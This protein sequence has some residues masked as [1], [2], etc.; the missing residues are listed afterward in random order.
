MAPQRKRE[1]RENQFYDVGV[2]GRK[3]GITL[4]DRGV[5]DEHGLEPIS[6]IFSS[7]ERSPPKRGGTVTASESMDIQESSI[8]DLTTSYQILRNSRT[9]LPPPRSRSPKKTALGSSPRRQSSIAPR[10]SSIGP[11][12]PARAASHP[13]VARRLDFEQDESSLQETPALSGSGQRRGK[14]SSVYDIPEDE[15]PMPQNS[16][17]LEESFVQEEITTNEDSLVINGVVEETSIA[18]VGDDTTN[19]AEA[20]ED[21]VNLEESEMTPEPVREPARR[22]RKRKSDVLEPTHQ[23]ESSALKPRKRGP[24]SAPAVETQKKGRNTVVVPAA[25]SRR[26]KR[27]SNTVEQE[28]STLDASSELSTDPVEVS[29]AAPAP[30]RRG[31]PPRAMVQP[32]KENSAPKAAKSTAVKT[33]A[34]SEFK[35]PPK[36][37]AKVKEKSV[38]RGKSD[39]QI[40]PINNDDAGKLVDVHGHPLSKKDIEQLSTTS[41]GSRYGRGRHLSVY[42]ELEPEAVARIGRTGRHRVA[43]IDFWKNDRIAYDPAGSMTSIVKNQDTEPERKSY[44][45][46]TKGKKR[47]LTVVEEEEVELDPW[48]EEEGILVGNYRDYDSTQDVISNDIVEDKIAWAQK[49]IKPIDV[50][51]GSFQYTKLSS[52]GD[53]FNWGLIELR[54][55]QMKRTKNSRKMHMVFNVQSGTV[56]VKVHENEFTVHKGGIWQVPRGKSHFLSLPFHSLHYLSHTAFLHL[57]GSLPAFEAAAS[58]PHF[59]HTQFGTTPDLFSAHRMFCAHVALRNDSVRQHRSVRARASEATWQTCSRSLQPFCGVRCPNSQLCMLC[60]IRRRVPLTQ[61]CCSTPMFSLLPSHEIHTA[62]GTSVAGRH[63]SFS[64]RL[65]RWRRLS[66]SSPLLCLS[67]RFPRSPILLFFQKPARAGR[68]GENNHLAVSC[69]TY[70]LE[71]STGSL[72]IV[73]PVPGVCDGSWWCGGVVVWVCGASAGGLSSCFAT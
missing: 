73:I 44:K 25:T 48:E 27:V 64:P 1:N 43:P 26:S 72:H 8:P 33:K 11:S 19:P 35:K 16:A 53:F 67:S 71:R 4:A 15:S 58:F 30:K 46:V 22:G 63:A 36:P 61:P 57:S 50:P 55:D 54:A 2:Q 68:S 34:S 70:V 5:Y 21:L 24:T 56:E 12:S 29:E 62:S 28:T 40:T 38:E 31:R 14:R 9:H 47:A 69:V 6:G 3:T 39:A 32:E 42:R 10:G 66:T 59:L 37:A 13:A 60:D 18:H 49:G 41:V 7:P 45:A 23:E 51:D 20:V 17:V 65:V 52:A